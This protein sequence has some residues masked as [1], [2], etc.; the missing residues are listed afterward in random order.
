MGIA[1]INYNTPAVHNTQTINQRQDDND[2]G[3]PYNRVPT[4][5]LDLFKSSI[6]SSHAV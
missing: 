4:P 1:P 5:P 3:K 6:Y 2:T